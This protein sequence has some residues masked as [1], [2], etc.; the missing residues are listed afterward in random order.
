MNASIALV[1][2]DVDGT[3]ITPGH[4][5]TARTKAA[6]RRLHDKGIQFTVASSRPPRGLE[7]IVEAL[8][9]A[10]PLAPFNGAQIVLSDGTILGK[11]IIPVPIIQRVF[12]ISSEYPLNL[13]VYRGREWFAQR[14]DEF[15][16][17]EEQT[18]GFPAQVDGHIENYFEDCPKLTVVG[19]P[20]VVEWCEQAVHQA[21]G[22][23]LEATRSKPRFL[24]IT[25][26][27]AN[28]GS[29]IT[30]LS[31]ILHIP[32]EQIAAIGDGPNDVEM[33][34]RA[35]FSIAMGNAGDFIKK[36]ARFVTTSNLEE[37]FANGME[38][39]VLKEENPGIAEKDS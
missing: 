5:I 33:F 10:L 13:W 31:R 25:V 35:G 30:T 23:Q 1:V 6:V 27:S 22:P 32:T 19:K 39:F 7:Q 8:Q 15:V 21:L 11:Q 24:D 14:R 29:V 20:E 26:K 3:L 16:E 12:Q 4:E 37:G 2:S 36:A 9:I 34:A 18:A 28:K 38:R 17:R